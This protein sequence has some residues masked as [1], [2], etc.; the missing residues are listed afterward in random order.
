MKALQK[1]ADVV[2]YINE[3][4]GKVFGFLIVV[5]MIVVVYDVCMRYFFNRPT[6]W[7]MELSTL[8]QVGV[9][10]LG[11]GYC[12]LHGGHV[13]VDIIYSRWSPRAKAIVDLITYLLLFGI[14]VVLVKL[15][16]ETAWDSLVH[17]KVS[18]SLWEPPLWPSQIL[19]PIGGIF[20]GLQGLAKWTR[21]WVTAA[22]GVKKLESKVVRGEGGLRG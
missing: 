16:G 3:W 12:L 7:G 9:M 13:K 4:L 8:L 6:A 2:D 17:H 21:D 18:V 5:M 22:T 19:I 1:F 11:A 10:F 14:C 20:I 15:G